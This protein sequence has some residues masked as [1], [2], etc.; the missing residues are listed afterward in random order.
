MRPLVRAVGL[1]VVAVLSLRAAPAS[2]YPW[3]VEHGYTACAQCHIDPSGGS[4]MT[5]Y[6]RAQ[7]EILL[8]SH[9]GKADAESSPGRAADFMFG[10]FDKANVDRQPG[11]EAAKTQFFGQVDAR[12]LV[13]PE[14]GNFRWILMQADLRAGVQTGLFTLYG[15]AGAVSD[16]GE[17]AW[18]TQNPDGFNLVSREYW[19]GITPAKGMMIRA[20][21]MSLPFGIRSEQHV[22]YTRSATRTTTNDDQQLGLSFNYGSRKIRAE[23]MGIA[24]NLQVAPDDFRERGYAGFIAWAPKNKIELGFS[25]QIRYAALDVDTSAPS[26]RQAHG[27]FGRYSPVAHFAIMGEADTTMNRPTSDVGGTTAFGGV[28]EL[29]IDAEPV[30]GLH[31]KAGGEYCDNDWSDNL[32]AVG[33][34]WGAAQW[35]FAPKVDLRV[36][37]LYG[38]L[39]CTPGGAAQPMALAQVHVYL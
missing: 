5:D 24:G 14:P 39:Y 35:F 16:G 18:L 29:E 17:G 19:A 23:I 6:G 4:A 31:L 26:L 13:I 28:A 27:V 11:A 10:V 36:D 32:A 2:A 15:S 21:R 12:G 20:G 8:R 25:S 37:G 38:A 3:M 22:L 30:Q 7:A 1:L 9:Y 33:T 34:G